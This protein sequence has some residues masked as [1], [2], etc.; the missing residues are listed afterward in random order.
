MNLIDFLADDRF[1]TLR[2]R[3]DAPLS[4]YK[5]TVSLPRPVF[6]E[7]VQVQTLL[8][9]EQGLEVDKAEIRTHLDGTLTFKGQRVLVHIRD[10]TNIRGHQYMPRFHLANC[11]TL[12]EMRSNGRFS[13]Y[14]VHDKDDGIFYI[15]LENSPIRAERLLVCQNCLDKLSWEGFN[16]DKPQTERQSIVAGFSIR[17]FFDRYP[18]SLHI[19]VPEYTSQTAPLNEYPENWEEISKE[20]RRQLR[21]QC[22]SCKIEL[23]EAHKRFLHVHHVNGLRNDCR[24]ENLSCLCIRCH[25]NQ[26]MHD[27]LKESTDYLEFIAK[28]KE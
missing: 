23:G 1:N 22:Q 19:T 26:P 7:R 18:R 6:K 17:R 9:P 12:I 16:R 25:A 28:F 13:R 21:Y 10:V 24:L 20:L 14:V 8:L 27:Q 2:S 11:T 5:L 15:R 3:I 4:F